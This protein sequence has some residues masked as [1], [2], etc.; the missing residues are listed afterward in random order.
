[1]RF[2]SRRMSRCSALVSIEASVPSRRRWKWLS[3]AVAL[4]GADVVLLGHSSLGHGEVPGDEHRDREAH[5]FEHAPVE[6]RDL[7]P[8]RVRERDAVALP[9]GRE[10]EQ[11]AVDDV[12]RHAPGWW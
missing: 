9:L 5:L 1:M 8:A 6:G 10:R 4:G 11:A 12:A 2:R 7:R 3:V